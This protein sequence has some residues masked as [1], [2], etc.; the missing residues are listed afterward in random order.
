MPT[1]T[2]ISLPK[3][4][5]DKI[6][7]NTIKEFA[8]KG[9]TLASTN[10]IAKE[11]NIS[12]GSMFQYF[13]TKEELF[14]FVVQRAL[15]EIVNVYKK[16]YTISFDNMDLRQ[17]F[18]TSCLQLIEFYDKYPYHY[19]LYLRIHYEIDS[20][21]YKE[22]RR[23]LSRYISAIVNR[24]IDVGKSK[25]I[26]KNDIPSD[27]LLFFINNFLFRFVEVHFDPDI[28]PTLNDS[29]FSKGRVI[30]GLNMIYDLFMEGIKSNT[31]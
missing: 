17:L 4:K 28:E 9:Y 31:S 21:N 30:E 7:Y 19:R 12:K 5:Q 25:N 10:K 11:S 18:I 22:I 24:F 3:A 26:I 6:F 13:V 14:F 27:L 20:P 16:K 23:Y 29:Y 2:F 1:K 15:S 8:D